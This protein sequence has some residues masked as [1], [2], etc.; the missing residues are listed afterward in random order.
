MPTAPNCVDTSADATLLLTATVN[1][2]ACINTARSDPAQ[3]LAD[4]RQAL[5]GWIAHGCFPKVVLAENSGVAAELFAEEA[6]LARTRG[7]AFEF[8]PCPPGDQ[9][10]ARGKG[11]GEL[12]IIAAA[13]AGSAIIA[14]GGSGAVVVKGTGRY[15]QANPR[16]LAALA[17]RGLD[18]CAVVCDLRGNL[19]HADS[20]VFAATAG[21]LVGHLLPQRV[22][23]DDR[24]YVFFEHVLARA[25][26][27]AMGAGASWRPLP[28]VPRIVGIG[29]TDNRGHRLSIPRRVRQA[30]LRH[31]IAY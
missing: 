8:V 5:R 15:V 20:R 12:G 6:A 17:A 21:F 26:H 3:R 4:Y 19:S 13:L 18:G 28:A 30:L 9:D 23:V 7:L 2:G 11:Y 31:L 22:V 16:T 25:V 29:G 24:K 27:T 1:P 10:P 14:A